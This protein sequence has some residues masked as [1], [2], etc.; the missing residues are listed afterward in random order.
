MYRNKYPIICIQNGNMPIRDSPHRDPTPPH[1]RLE[2][3]LETPTWRPAA[4][5]ETPTWK[6]SRR[7]GNEE[8]ATWKPMW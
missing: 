6:P 5:L 2:A 8:I 7:L 1:A 3:D 4:D